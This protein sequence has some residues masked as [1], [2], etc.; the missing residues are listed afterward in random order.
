M[1]AISTTWVYT[2]GVS[3]GISNLEEA[4][5]SM[6]EEDYYEVFASMPEKNVT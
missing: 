4:F 5:S 6:S 3:S 2:C 1:R